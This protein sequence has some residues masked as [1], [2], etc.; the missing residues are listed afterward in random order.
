MAK[1]TKASTVIAYIRHDVPGFENKKLAL[2]YFDPVAEAH[3]PF[4]ESKNN[5]IYE[6]EN[7]ELLQFKMGCNNKS[8]KI[9]V[10]E[11]IEINVPSIVKE[12]AS[13]AVTKP[14]KKNRVVQSFHIG[15]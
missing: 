2:F 10:Q 11:T 15:N 3:D 12:S 6:N 9:L 1:S 13:N 8:L 14:K 5:M 7:V 4:L